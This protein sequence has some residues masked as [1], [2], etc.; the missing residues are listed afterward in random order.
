MTPAERL[1]ASIQGIKSS[2]LN[3]DPP[4]LNIGQHYENYIGWILEQHGIV[5]KFEDLIGE[6]G[7]GSN[8]AQLKAVQHIADYLEMFLSKD[9]ISDICKRIFWP[10]AQTFRKGQI[11]S[12]KEHFNS[13]HKRFSIASS[14]MQ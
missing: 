10:K 8:A 2:Q 14:E 6:L 9:K 3:G 11:G 12:W 1:M 5:V 4:S 13:D 7:G